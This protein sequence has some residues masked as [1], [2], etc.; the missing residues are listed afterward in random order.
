M[1]P[2]D[3]EP[4]GPYYNGLGKSLGD[5][6]VIYPVDIPPV[7]ISTPIPDEPKLPVIIPILLLGAFFIYLWLNR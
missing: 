6:V 7:P 1:R 5:A 3:V 2:F 4:V